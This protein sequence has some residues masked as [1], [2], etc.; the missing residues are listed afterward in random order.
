VGAQQQPEKEVWIQPSAGE[1]KDIAEYQGIL[2]QMEDLWDVYQGGNIRDKIGPLKGRMLSLSAKTGHGLDELEAR[3]IALNAAI[4][5]KMV[6]ML[7]G[8]QMSQTE[9]E[10]YYEQIPR[11]E[12][13]PKLWEQKF[14]ATREN[15]AYLL[16]LRTAPFHT[17]NPDFLEKLKTGQRN[18][19]QIKTVRDPKTGEIVTYRL[20][21]AGQWELVE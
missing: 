16:G 4:K 9:R 17:T 8:K 13:P 7:T 20:N 2:K 11:P 3:Y 5:N 12:D 19:P 15:F 18:D 6:F 10:T 14:Q 21:D 1:R